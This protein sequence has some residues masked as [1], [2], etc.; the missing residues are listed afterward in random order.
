MQIVYSWDNLHEMLN[1]VVWENK[2]KYFYMTFA[3]KLPRVLGVKG[4]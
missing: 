1:P 4:H 3:E 2:E